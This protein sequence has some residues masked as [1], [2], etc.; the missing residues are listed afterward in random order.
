MCWQK[1]GRGAGCSI[2][3]ANHKIGQLRD[4]DNDNNSGDN[5]YI[6]D[7]RSILIYCRYTRYVYSI[8]YDFKLYFYL[9]YASALPHISYTLDFA[10]L[11]SRGLVQNSR[12]LPFHCQLNTMG[13]HSLCIYILFFAFR[14]AKRS[15][16][17]VT[18]C[19]LGCGQ[20]HVPLP[21]P[22]VDCPSTLQQ[23]FQPDA[24]QSRRYS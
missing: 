18:E 12:G 14:I 9:L 2:V 3:P 5:L 6:V 4:N 24:F 19:L 11:L 13:L 21:P 20:G 1:D 16:H 22:P 10:F 7:N 23:D 8:E 15:R 17:T